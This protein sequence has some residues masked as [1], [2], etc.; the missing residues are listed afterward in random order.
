MLA[1]LL[2]ASSVCQGRDILNLHSP[3][4]SG[5]CCLRLEHLPQALKV[6]VW[7]DSVL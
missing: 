3:F 6:S 4:P 2:E 7:A 5:L 1:V